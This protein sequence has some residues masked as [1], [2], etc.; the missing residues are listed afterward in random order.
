V[1]QV[2]VS[3]PQPHRYSFH[4]T[5]HCLRSA[6]YCV[7]SSRHRVPSSTNVNPPRLTRASRRTVKGM[8]EG[9]LEVGSQNGLFHLR[10]DSRKLQGIPKG[11]G[12]SKKSDPLG[13]NL[14]SCDNVLLAS[15]P[16]SGESRVGSPRNAKVRLIRCSSSY[17]LDSI[18]TK[19]LVM[20]MERTGL[21]EDCNS[22]RVRK[23][24]RSSTS[25]RAVRLTF[26][27]AILL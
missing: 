2:S 17:F 25:S 15:R 27:R 22:F 18:T 1:C 13:T 4:L 21:E 6:V 3:T 23:S 19:S 26:F 24:S 5:H 16:G 9:E 14:D 8:P 12:N 11:E 20:L 10:E 7:S